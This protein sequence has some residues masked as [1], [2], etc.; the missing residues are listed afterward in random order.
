MWCIN[1]MP[2]LSSCNHLSV[3]L[4]PHHLVCYGLRDLC[5][6]CLR[7]TKLCLALSSLNGV[8]STLHVIYFS[9]KKLNSLPT[10]FWSS[11]SRMF[12][13][14]TSS[15]FYPKNCFDL[16]AI[17]VRIMVREKPHRM[18][19]KYAKVIKVGVEK[20]LEDGFIRRVKNTESVLL[21]NL[22]PKKMESWVFV[23]ITGKLSVCVHYKKVNHVTKED[24]CSYSFCDKFLE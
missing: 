13:W 24:R 11:D 8:F 4:Y 18:N 23:C 3:S 17:E 16:L 10:M 21:I 19:P 20:L 14:E 5:A 22:A 9:L 7:S 12:I 15:K 1:V 6:T 2:K